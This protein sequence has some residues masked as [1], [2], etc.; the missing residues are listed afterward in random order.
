MRLPNIMVYVT[1]IWSATLN[2]KISLHSSKCLTAKNTKDKQIYSPLIK[3]NIAAVPQ[4][5]HPIGL[6]P[7]VL[8]SH[9]LIYFFLS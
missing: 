9:F 2:F 8:C 5:V 6:R 7:K 1:W 3:C 4:H